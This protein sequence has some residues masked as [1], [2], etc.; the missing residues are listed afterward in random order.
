MKYVEELKGGIYMYVGVN[1]RG[2]DDV[3]VMP[4]WR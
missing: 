4:I 2:N 1:Y 3:N